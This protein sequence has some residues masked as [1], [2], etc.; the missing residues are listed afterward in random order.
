MSIYRGTSG[1]LLCLLLSLIVSPASAQSPV[2]KD[3]LVF[4]GTGARGQ[5]GFPAGRQGLPG[6]PLRPGPSPRRHVS[7]GLSATDLGNP[8]VIGGYA[9]LF[10]RRVAEHY[11][12]SRLD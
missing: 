5:A 3:V 10:Y 11:G 8:E 4:G 2:N 6:R 12:R 7:G 9:K 1:V